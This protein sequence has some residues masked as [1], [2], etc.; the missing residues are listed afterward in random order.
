[1]M[2]RELEIRRP[3]A[4]KKEELVYKIR[5]EQASAG[6]TK[7]N[8]ADKQKEE[9]KEEKKKRPKTAAKKDDKKNSA[10]AKENVAPAANAK[11]KDAVKKVE[12]RPAESTKE[13]IT[14]EQQDHKVTPY[15]TPNKKNPR[16]KKETSP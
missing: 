1:M 7:K 5:D 11:P 15:A 14:T 13:T 4:Y 9:R 10:P 2:T 16:S 8:A 6:A 3:D 12:S